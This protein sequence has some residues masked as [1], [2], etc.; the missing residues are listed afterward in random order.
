MIARQGFSGGATGTPRTPDF[1]S[2]CATNPE[3]FISSMK[4][5]A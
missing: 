5:F 3:A 2:A 1:S 4:T